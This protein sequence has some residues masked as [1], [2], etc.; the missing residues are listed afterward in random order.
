MSMS[1]ICNPAFYCPLIRF[2]GAGVRPPTR[3]R[4][5]HEFA[6]LRTYPARGP[7]LFSPYVGQVDTAALMLLTH[8]NSSAS[9]SASIQG[10]VQKAAAKILPPSLG[11]ATY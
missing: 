6:T 1:H 11:T 5:G 9:I 7:A 8:T 4:G 3:T 2:L 10:D